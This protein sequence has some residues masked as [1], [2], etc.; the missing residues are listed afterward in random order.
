MPF[1]PCWNCGADCFSGL[2]KCPHCGAARPFE[3][4]AAPASEPA[5]APEAVARPATE[6]AHPPTTVRT[7]PRCGA[8]LRP[9]EELCPDCAREP[10]VEAISTLVPCRAC[11]QLV[12][13][14]ASTCPR[15]GDPI[16]PLP[17]VPPA[18]PPPLAR[19]RH[20][21]TVA[22][23]LALFLGGL[24]AHKFYLHRPGLGVLYLLFSWTLIPS[25]VGV[26]EAI[27]Y[28]FSADEEFERRYG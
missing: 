2:E 25:V 11:G 19:P 23:A 21:R 28:A 15:C 17:A 16:A 10:Q 20:R 7:C 18:P 6:P 9:G 3:A 24:G 14:R 8:I 12:S 1:G 4:A 26:V 5:R 27:L 22:A 13:P